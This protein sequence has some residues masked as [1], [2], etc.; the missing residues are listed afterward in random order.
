[1]GPSVEDDDDDVYE[2]EFFSDVDEMTPVSRFSYPVNAPTL[3]QSPPLCCYCEYE[4]MMRT[5]HS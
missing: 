1:M 3:I 4:F 2:E 5:Q